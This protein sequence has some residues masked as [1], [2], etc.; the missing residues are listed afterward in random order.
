MLPK[1]RGLLDAPMMAI[2]FGEKMA[3]RSVQG[4]GRTS[5]VHATGL[6]TST[7][8]VG[9]TTLTVST[10]V[11]VVGLDPMNIFVEM[12]RRGGRGERGVC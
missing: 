7:G 2:D 6:E 4:G 12:K 10:L 8:L 9:S 3:F 5:L 1:A 11:G